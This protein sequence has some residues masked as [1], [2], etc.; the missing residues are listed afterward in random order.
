MKSAFIYPVKHKNTLEQNGE[1]GHKY[2]IIR[3]AR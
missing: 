1:F 3:P 2:T